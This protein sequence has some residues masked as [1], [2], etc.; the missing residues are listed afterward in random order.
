MS[1][2][3]SNSDSRA[4]YMIDEALQS[5]LNGIKD[6]QQRA[7]RAADEISRSFEPESTSDGLAAIVELTQ[8]LLQ[9]KA[10]G[11]VIRTADELSKSAIDL[12]A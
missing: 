3:R 6:A 8:S 9:H 5:G 12:L 1:T 11:A 2:F 4:K 10:S 7:A